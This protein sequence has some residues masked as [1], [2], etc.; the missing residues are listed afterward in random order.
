MDV[1]NAITNCN[2]CDQRH[3]REAPKALTRRASNTR[4]GRPWR[5]ASKPQSGLLDKLNNS[6]IRALWVSWWYSSRDDNYHHRSINHHNTSATDARR[7]HSMRET[8]G[9]LGKFMPQISHD[10]R[11]INNKTYIKKDLQTKE[12]K[13]KA[14]VTRMP[15]VMHNDCW[16]S[17]ESCCLAEPVTPPLVTRE[18]VR[19]TTTKTT[20]LLVIQK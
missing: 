14:I 1:I 7:R 18:Q 13:N 9:R 17:C 3:H 19:V 16:T 12:N 6:V 20:I 15:C 2:R 10:E 11:G 5:S 8:S 4:Q